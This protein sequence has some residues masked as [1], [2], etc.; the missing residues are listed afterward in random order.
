ALRGGLRD[1]G[2]DGREGGDRTGA[3]VVAVREAAGQDHGVDAVEVVR[4]VPQGHGF[5]ARG[6]DGALRVAVVE[7]TREGD[8]ADAGRHQ[9]TSMLTTTSMT[10]FERISS[11]MV[12]ASAS[13][14]S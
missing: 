9:T 14:S 11:A 5:G 8:D 3:Q 12:L 7:R 10:W 2:H 4:A 13:T 1:L 6:A